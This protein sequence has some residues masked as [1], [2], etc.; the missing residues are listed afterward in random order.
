MVLRAGLNQNRHQRLVMSSINDS[1][2][3]WNIFQIWKSE[4]R[5]SSRIWKWHENAKAHKLRIRT[6]WLFAKI[7]NWQ[8]DLHIFQNTWDLL[9]DFCSSSKKPHSPGNMCYSTGH[10]CTSRGLGAMKTTMVLSICSNPFYMKYSCHYHLQIIM[11]WELHSYKLEKYISRGFEVLHRTIN[12]NF[13]S[14]C[15]INFI[16]IDVFISHASLCSMQWIAVR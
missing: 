16:R 2:G 1:S 13:V 7:A 8:I 11:K 3:N 9:P 14:R 6:E 4:K 5:G 12:Y 15:T 10:H